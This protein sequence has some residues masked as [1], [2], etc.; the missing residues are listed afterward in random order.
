MSLR[1]CSVTLIR[2]KSHTG[3]WFLLQQL[4][5]FVFIRDESS[6][7]QL[8]S[9]WFTNPS[10][11]S[12]HIVYK[13]SKTQDVLNAFKIWR[14]VTIWKNPISLRSHL[15]WSHAWLLLLSYLLEEGSYKGTQYWGRDPSSPFFACKISILTVL[16]KEYKGLLSL[17][18]RSKD[19]ITEVMECT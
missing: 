4:N 3:I 18:I 10:A 12:L 15:H 17:E 8:W 7:R 9:A 13:H 19:L 11:H 16:C 5:R 14:S 1:Y 6:H 2:T